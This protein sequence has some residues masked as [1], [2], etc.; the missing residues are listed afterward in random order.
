MDRKWV[1][2]EAAAKNIA[3]GAVTVTCIVITK[4]PW[5]A[6]LLLLMF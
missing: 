3:I 5:F 2:I 6:F 4:S 1:W